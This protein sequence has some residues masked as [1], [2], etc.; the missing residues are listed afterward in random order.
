MLI[1]WSEQ[2]AWILVSLALLVGGALA[3]ALCATL[4][5]SE[6]TAGSWPGLI[7]G[8]MALAM[9]VFAGLLTPRKKLR[10]LPL[11]SAAWW[12]RGHV[13]FG[14]LSLPYVFFHSGF[15][16]GGVYTQALL[17]LFILCYASG[18]H[19]LI[20]Q[21][22]VPRMLLGAVTREMI[23]ER[24]DPL[25]QSL[26]ESSLETV[27]KTCG[28]F[29]RPLGAHLEVIGGPD[30][31][32]HVLLAERELFVFGREMDIPV[33]ITDP[34]VAPK[35]FEVLRTGGKYL[36]GA[37][38]GNT[39]LVNDQPIERR[40]LAEGDK[41]RVG[42]T[43]LQFSHPT[44]QEVQVLKS[45]FVED[46]QPFLL[47]KPVPAA[48]QKFRTVE[49]ITNAFGHV[50]KFI[51]SE[52]LKKVI[53]DLLDSTLLRRELLICKRLH[54]WLNGWLIL[55]IPMAALLLFGSALHAVISLL[56]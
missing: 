38:E 43:L 3:H 53:D 29:N 32:T 21:Q 25:I 18:I 24:I 8:S 51:Q 37:R 5:P 56:Y 9:M 1:R 44:P 48:I 31:G 27:R 45:F 4:A 35:H 11:G 34:T 14:L 19:G 30:N 46:V 7:F 15:E 33:V 47:P 12:M 26:A 40:E 36:L 52:N 22:I 6:E 54:H 2:R 10:A 17:I 23:Y 41:I 28:P 39:V 50:R 55:H 42:D 16:I 13:W 20:V 49:D